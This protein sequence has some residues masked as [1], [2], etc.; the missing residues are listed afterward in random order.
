MLARY[1]QIL[2][3]RLCAHLAGRAIN[4][5]HS[6]LP[7]LQGREAVS[8]GARAR[9]EAHRRD[10]A[11]R[12]GRSRRRPDHRAGRRARGSHAARRKSLTAIGGELESV[13]LNRAL[14]W[15][16]EQRVFQF[17]SEDGGAAVGFLSEARPDHIGIW[18]ILH[19]GVVIT[20]TEAP[21]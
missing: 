3:P 18:R 8:P 4:I 19:A 14:Q 7:E 17:G 11:L 16:A 9:R 15:H 2:S 10:R 5:H 12:D 20:V 13:V 21:R 6:F 1:M